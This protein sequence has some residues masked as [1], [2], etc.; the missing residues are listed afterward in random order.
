MKYI[1]FILVFLSSATF[2]N[3][4]INSEDSYNRHRVLLQQYN[5][6]IHK[7]ELW[8]RTK[9]DSI[10][11]VGLTPQ[12][13]LS[14][15]ADYTS[16]T[17]NKVSYFQSKII[18]TQA[19]IKQYEDLK[20]NEDKHID[21]TKRSIESSKYQEQI[22]A[23]QLQRSKSREDSEKRIIDNLNNLENDLRNLQDRALAREI[24]LRNNASRNFVK[25]NL[26]TY[27]RI[28]ETHRKIPTGNFEKVL[29]GKYKANIIF[30]KQY[31]FID[32]KSL[33]TV[34][35][36]I[37]NITEDKVV[38]I[39][40]YG[41]AEFKVDLTQKTSSSWYLSN[42]MIEYTDIQSHRVTRV[43]ILMPYL[44]SLKEELI[45]AKNNV[46]YIIPYVN[47]KQDEGKVIWIQVW[48][49]SKNY[50]LEEFPITLVYA[51]SKKEAEAN[52]TPI[53]ISS[54]YDVYFMGPPGYRPGNVYLQLYQVLKG[55]KTKPLKNGEY[56][57]VSIS[58]YRE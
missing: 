51:T 31:S 2:V 57:V 52:I 43:V 45:I 47:K 18:T 5:S 37:V 33:T 19:A 12:Q 38:E 10:S 56:R 48:N 7:Q 20:D 11:K 44:T 26:S 50:I 42:G 54:G 23:L 40:P 34:V 17:Q 29:N 1:I 13:Q 16:E 22:N 30:E 9:R 53:P 25:Y 21:E 58:K 49:S 3:S 32:F 6:E 36:V 28:A 55:P 4:Q 41:D 39:Y 24:S 46:G 35:P 27:D 8:L 15:I 14:Y